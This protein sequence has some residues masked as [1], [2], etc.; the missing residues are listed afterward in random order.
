MSAGTTNGLVVKKTDEDWYSINVPAFNRLTATINFTHSA[1]DLDM[2]LYASDCFTV[3]DY[4]GGTTNSETVQGDNNTASTV[5]YRVQVY[6]FSGSASNCNVYNMTLTLTS[7]CTPPSITS[8][9]SSQTVFV[10]Q[11]VCFS[12]SASGSTPLSYQWQRDSVDIPGATSPTYC[13]TAQASD[14][15]A[16]YRCVVTNSCGSATSNSATLTV[17]MITL[18]ASDPPMDGTLPKTQNNVILLTFDGPITLP[19]GPA[20]SIRSLPLPGAEVGGSF[21]YTLP[22]S[23]ILKAKENGA[24]LT[25][26][27]WYRVTPSAGL[28]ALAFTRDFCTL[29]GDADNSG[30]VTALDYFPIKNHP[31]EMTDARYDLDGS[32][33]VTA[34]DYFVVK[35]HPFDAKPPKP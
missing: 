20:L 4:S 35:L 15:G 32:G 6:V 5:N 2:F 17:N 13:F 18:L 10:G 34:L 24:V 12:V 30:Q 9:P 21:T 11:S 8:H 25:N 22:G 1:G 16:Q 7:I 33:Q 19:G 3:I 31:F 23:T 29:Q 26:Q 27:T 28:N 14:N